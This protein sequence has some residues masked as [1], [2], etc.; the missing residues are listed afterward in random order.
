MPEDQIPALKRALEAAVKQSPEMLRRQID[1]AR[2][3]ARV[4]DA[5]RERWPNIGGEMKY[6]S[7]QT[8][9]STDASTKSRDSGLFYNF[10]ASQQVF[11]WGAIKRT[12]DIAKIELAIGH[13]EYAEAYRLLALEIRQGFLNLIWR[14]G[15]VEWMRGNLRRAETELANTREKFA[16]GT[17]STGDVGTREINVDTAQLELERFLLEFDGERRRV[18]RMAGLK[19]IPVEDIPVAI[20]AP[21]YRADVAD[22]MLAALLR[23]GGR[24]TFRAQ[25]A[26]MHRREADLSYKIA[27]VRLL[28]K[29]SA[30]INHSRE[31]STTATPTSISQTAITRDTFEV[32]GSWTVF[33]G[34]ATRAAKLMA[35]ADRRASER[36]LQVATDYAMD[37]A[38][39][40][41]RILSIDNR[42]LKLN[43]YRRGAAES[44]L[45]R[46]QEEFKAGRAA[47]A[48]LDL[49]QAGLQSADYSLA[50]A[51]GT[52]FADWSAFVSTV[53]DDPVL[54]NLPPRYVRAKP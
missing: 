27:R 52:F 46:T 16:H 53:T 3:E 4:I 45:S 19:E 31:S 51:R 37:E 9:I 33:D 7:T 54:T 50:Q 15:Q 47:Q 39:R 8:A 23:D 38:Q 14:K 44:Y 22:E 1:V 49:A 6:D 20:P 11:Q 28:P 36:E 12:G 25:V 35:K 21:R 10:G 48:E 29:F 30:N 42:S 17:A 24:T 40:L 32:R 5:Y 13:K 43:E 34:F 18:G 41:A 26:E 2:S